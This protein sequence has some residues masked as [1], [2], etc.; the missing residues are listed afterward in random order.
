M[1]VRM[2]TV[3]MIVILSM[4]VLS[5]AMWCAIRGPGAVVLDPVVIIV[6]KNIPHLRF[7]LRFHGPSIQR[8]GAR[9]AGILAERAGDARIGPPGIAAIACGARRDHFAGHRLRIADLVPAAAPHQIDM[10]VVVV[11]AVGARRQH[12]G[13]LLAGRALDVAQESLLFRR[14]APAVLHGDPAP[15]GQREGSDV[16]RIAE[17]MFGNSRAGLAVHAAAGIGGDLLDL[18]HRLAEPAHRRGL[19]RLRDPLIERGDDRTGERRRRLDL[20]RPDR[21][22]GVAPERHAYRCARWRRSHAGRLRWRG[23]DA[24]ASDSSARLRAAPR[25]PRR[26]WRAPTARRRPMAF[27]ARPRVAHVI[28]LRR[29]SPAAARP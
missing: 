23:A 26:R 2:R 18:G 14:A 28:A 15:V 16:E 17:G 24:A 13:E 1:C 11:E 27:A 8:S 5:L 9:S 19:H 7:R 12:G 22:N 29:D 25:H 21:G 10:D 20:D 3:R 6:G 4:I